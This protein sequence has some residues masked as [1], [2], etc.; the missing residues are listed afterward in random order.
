MRAAHRGVGLAALLLLAAL[1]P[2]SALAQDDDEVLP[3][4]VFAGPHFRLG[5]HGEAGGFLSRFPGAYGG[6]EVLAGVR[7]S[8]ELSIVARV[9]ADL[10]G[11]DNGQGADLLTS[12]AG[13]AGVEYVVLGAFGPGSGLALGLTGGV[14]LPDACGD[15]ACPFLAPIGLAHVAWLFGGGYTPTNPLAA[16]SLGLSGGVGYDVEL[17]EAAGRVTLYFGYELS[18]N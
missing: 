4:P 10:G 8:T 11:W 18:I 3:V 5:V 16:F 7:V 1:A 2:S 15:G 14:Y 17:Q 9:N 6:L 12:I 13:G